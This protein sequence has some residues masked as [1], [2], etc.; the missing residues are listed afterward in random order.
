MKS[1]RK[2]LSTGILRGK[3]R[4]MACLVI[5]F[6]RSLIDG[7]NEVMKMSTDFT[8]KALISSSHEI[9]N[10]KRRATIEEK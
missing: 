10:S 5:I 3:L 9:F 8:L 6:K 4:I 7:V 1:R 2:Q